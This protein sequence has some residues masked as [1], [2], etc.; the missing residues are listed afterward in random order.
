M[1]ESVRDV[2]RDVAGEIRS[3]HLGPHPGEKVHPASV[4]GGRHESREDAGRD[5]L[6]QPL[7]QTDVSRI[8]EEVEEVCVRS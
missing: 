8:E 6:R 1:H 7:R 3:Q 5:E 4:D 2:R